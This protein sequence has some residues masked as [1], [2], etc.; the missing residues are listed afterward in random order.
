[1]CHRTA[2]SRSTGAV[3]HRAICGGEGDPE[4]PT[5]VLLDLEITLDEVGYC[6]ARL[7]ELFRRFAGLDELAEGGGAQGL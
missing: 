2:L 3:S 6:H 1:M 7:N 4:K 5:A